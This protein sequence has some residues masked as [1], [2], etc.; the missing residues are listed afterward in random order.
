M[1]EKTLSTSDEVS[2]KN[3]IWDERNETHRLL[4]QATKILSQKTSLLSLAATN[5][6]DVYYSGVGNILSR[7]EFLDLSLTRNLFERLDEVAFWER[8]LERFARLNEDILYILGEDDFSDPIFAG[9][10]SVWG[11]FEGHEIK[12]IIGVVGPKRM[13]YDV[14]TPQIKYFSALLGDIIKNQVINK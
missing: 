2:Y 9:C 7:D 6:G 1:K 14:V 8:V 4:S 5:L 10:A 3:S 12:G 13:Y 11:E